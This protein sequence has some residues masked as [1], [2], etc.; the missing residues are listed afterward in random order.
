MLGSRSGHIVPDMQLVDVAVLYCLL[1]QIHHMHSMYAEAAEA[2]AK[3]QPS[4]LQACQLLSHL[5][6]H[7]DSHMADMHVS[8]VAL[9]TSF[10]TPL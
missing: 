9:E 4:L 5:T 7:S 6:S 10:L 8:P 3:G 1:A 2:D